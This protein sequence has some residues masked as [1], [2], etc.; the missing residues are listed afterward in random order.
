MIKALRK[1]LY[2]VA[3]VL[4]LAGIAFG[5]SA[6]Y[7][8][9]LCDETM[10]GE[11]A[12]PPRFSTSFV[13]YPDHYMDLADEPGFQPGWVVT[14]APIN[15]EYGKA[16]YIT[17]FGRMLARGTPKIVTQQHAQ[18]D[19]IIERFRREFAKLDARV[20]VGD[21]LSNV[22]SVLGDRLVPFTNSDGS[23]FADFQY[24]FP[25]LRSLDRVGCLTNGIVLN[26]SNGIV[27][28]K[29]YSFISGR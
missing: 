23:I 14:Y 4:A 17:F 20:H 9:K 13:L 19:I 18:D 1:A 12:P 8:R 29:N 28:W 25:A 3:L 7:A 5:F 21:T 15:R 6:Y 2:T 22:V 27:V 16:F 11:V 24:G 26:V 10:R